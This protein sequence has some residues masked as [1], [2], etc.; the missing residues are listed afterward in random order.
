[1]PMDLNT[2]LLKDQSPTSVKEKAK[3]CVVSYRE[4]VGSLNWAAVGT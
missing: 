3:M 4:S 2:Q 1:M